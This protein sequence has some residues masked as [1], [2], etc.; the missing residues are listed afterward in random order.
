MQDTA[1]PSAVL[2]AMHQLTLAYRRHMRAAVHMQALELT[3]NGLK[4]L[5]FV[6]QHPLCT[7]KDVMAHTGADK[8]QIARLLQQMEDGQWLERVAHPQDKRSRCL[9]LSPQGDSA[10]SALGAQRQSLGRHMLQS[11]DMAQQ[12]QLLETLQ[13]MHAQLAALPLLPELD[14]D[15]A[16]KITLANLP[17]LHD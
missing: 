17:H 13:Q 10:F 8:A 11:C 3:P 6:G 15:V 7:H 4:V 2:D 1:L 9:R 12:Q 16:R 5:L 14:A